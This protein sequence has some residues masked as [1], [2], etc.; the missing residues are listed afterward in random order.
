MALALVWVV[1]R[2]ATSTGQWADHIEQFVRAHG[3]EWGYH[4]HPPFATWLLAGAIALFGPAVAWPYLLAS[5]CMLGT[6]FF[7][8]RVACRLLGRRAAALAIL[9]WG[10][11]Y[12]FSFRASLF[13]HDTVMILCVSAA[14]WALLHAL[15][16]GRTARVWWLGVGVA[17]ALAFLSKY[18]AVVPITGL[19]FGAWRGGALA[20]PTGRHG[21]LV[22]GGA[23]AVLVAPHLAWLLAGHDAALAY[24]TQEGHLLPWAGRASNVLGFLVQQLR[25][26]IAPLLFVGLVLLLPKRPMDAGA[27]ETPQVGVW[28]VALVAIPLVATVLAG[29]LFGLALQNHWG[30]QAL[31]FVGLWLAWRVTARSAASVRQWIGVALLVHAIALGIAVATADAMPSR[32]GRHNESRFP[33][34]AVADAVMRDW[35]ASTSC[36]LAIVVGPYFESGIVSV[37]N[38]GTARVL[39]DGDFAKSPWIAPADLRRW[40]AVH[41]SLDP[42]ALPTIGVSRTGSFD[43]SAAAPPPANHVY[44][45]IVPPP[46]CASYEPGLPPR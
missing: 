31:Q 30:Y 20:S 35:R 10:L 24:A 39:E 42:K 25:Y 38:G 45:A 7:T 23:A 46:G 1:V 27:R 26:L 16:G 2:L 15:S 5:S 33:A 29:P 34:Q 44:W 21:V 37:Y 28:M 32:T 19:A 41:V 11:Q 14:A 18:Q 43:V 8:H 13:N 6:A 12:P 4:K 3:R 36:P 17:S 9:I 40:G 22:A